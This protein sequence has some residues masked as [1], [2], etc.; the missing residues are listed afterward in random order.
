MTQYNKKIVK[1]NSNVD[2]LLKDEELL[3][4]SSKQDV[5]HS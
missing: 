4:L 5:Y 3:K 1:L 2:V